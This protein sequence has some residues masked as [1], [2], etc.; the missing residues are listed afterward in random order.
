[1]LFFILIKLFYSHRHLLHGRYTF[2]LFISLLII[3]SAIHAGSR[4]IS[5]RSISI[6][7]FTNL[8]HPK[9]S[10]IVFDKRFADATSDADGDNESLKHFHKF[11]NPFDR[12]YV[13]LSRRFLYQRC[14]RRYITIP[15]RN[16][17]FYFIP[18]KRIRCIY[19]ANI[20]KKYFI[21]KFYYLTLPRCRADITFVNYFLN[22]RF[23]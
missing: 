3:V 13:A 6:S 20:N 12:M 1:V 2:V 19:Y 14:A 9:P 11:A 23:L 22:S 8:S 10:F 18:D 15:D 5:S 21:V 7:R 16:F 4:T 17:P